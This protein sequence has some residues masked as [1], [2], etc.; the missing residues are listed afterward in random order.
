MSGSTTTRFRAATAARPGS[1]SRRSSPLTR[2]LAEVKPE[3]EAAWRDEEIAKRLSDKATELVK[4]LDGGQSL[5]QFAAS[6]GN[7]P[8]AHDPN[9]KRAGAPGL[10]ERTRRQ[11]LRRACRSGG[12]GPHGRDAR[13]MFKVL[14]SVV[15]PLDPQAPR[16]HAGRR[17]LQVRPRPRTFL[18]PILRKVGRGRHQD[19]PG[20][21]HAARR[22]PPSDAQASVSPA[23]QRY[24]AGEARSSGRSLSPI[25][26]RRSPP[27]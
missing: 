13:M 25:S 2:A 15:P 16:K 11:S 17:P 14:D 27:S 5:E 9:V 21:A 3:V 6:L 1:K 12:L 24:D 7:P 18:R 22:A 10:A 20:R 23:S 26:K 4:S 8:V 19:Q